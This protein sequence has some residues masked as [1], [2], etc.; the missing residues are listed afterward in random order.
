V[1]EA[2]KKGKGFGD[3]SKN[4]NLVEREEDGKAGEGGECHS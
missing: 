4:N 1:L 2:E 3:E